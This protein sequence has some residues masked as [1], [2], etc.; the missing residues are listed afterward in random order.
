MPQISR[1]LRTQLAARLQGSDAN[2]QNSFNLNF[3]A[4][5]QAYGLSPQVI[6]WPSSGIDYT[7]NSHNL[8][9]GRVSPDEIDTSGGAFVYP[10]LTIDTLRSRNSN[11]VKY[12]TF[13]GPVTA[14]IDVH[15]SWD[16]SGALQDFA[17][18]SDA[19]EDALFSTLLHDNYQRWSNGI[20][21]DWSSATFSKD[22]SIRPGG[23]GWRRSHTF[24]ATFEVITA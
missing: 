10:L 22:A 20:L 5:L 9:W 21:P 4:A 14:S 13:A 11:Y 7:A 18:W 12:A 16:A 3:S 19:L 6:R 23:Y 15:L 17:T 2:G 24:L 1:L 8:I